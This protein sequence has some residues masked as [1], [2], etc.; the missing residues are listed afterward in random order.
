VALQLIGFEP[1]RAGG[2]P[3]AAAD[4]RRDR[5]LEALGYIN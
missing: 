3:V 1:L 4:A 2:S 5:D